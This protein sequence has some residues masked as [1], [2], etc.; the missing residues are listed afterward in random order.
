MADHS[1]AD[2]SGTVELNLTE[3]REVTRYA[4]A[5]A[6]PAVAIFERDR[7]DDQRPRTAIEAAQAFAD[8]APRTKALR[9]STPWP[10]RPRSNTSLDRPLTPHEHSKSPPRTIPPSA[11]TTKQQAHNSNPPAETPHHQSLPNRRAGS[12]GS[13]HRAVGSSAGSSP[14]PLRGRAPRRATRHPAHPPRPGPT[15]TTPPQRSSRHLRGGALPRGR[16]EPILHA[17]PVC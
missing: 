16:H 14:H 8:G 1:T 13:S 6:R 10:K 9:S 3:L 15:R 12:S 4:A 7:P 17:Y 5:C 11:P 2:D